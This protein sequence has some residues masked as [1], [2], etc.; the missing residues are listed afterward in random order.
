MGNDDLVASTDRIGWGASAWGHPNN[1]RASSTSA[2]EAPC[3]R[4]A[5]DIPNKHLEPH[6]IYGTPARPLVFVD[7]P[8]RFRKMTQAETAKPGS[9]AHIESFNIERARSTSPRGRGML[10]STQRSSA[11][12]HHQG[13][14]ANR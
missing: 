1:P 11:P 2:F 6:A 7:Q 12:R 14:R 10:A 5:N 13:V 3:R 4:C 9:I 8:L